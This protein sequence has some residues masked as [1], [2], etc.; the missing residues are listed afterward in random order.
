MEFFL[1]DLRKTF[2]QTIS[3]HFFGEKSK[4]LAHRVYEQRIQPALVR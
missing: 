1:K 4:N 3:A 2:I